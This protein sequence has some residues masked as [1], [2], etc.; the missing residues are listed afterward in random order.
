MTNDKLW[1]RNICKRNNFDISEKQIDLLDAYVVRL[2]EWNS[3]IN[4]ISRRD[5]MNVWSRH[6]LGSVA[7]LFR[8]NLKTPAD[9]V[10]VGT[11]GGL[12]GVPLA[13]VLPGCRFT[14]VDS[15]QKKL[16]AL[17]DIL[18]HLELSNAGIMCGRAEDLSTKKPLNHAFDYVIARAVAPMKDIVKWSSGFLKPAQA[19]PEEGKGGFH[20][21]PGAIL[22]LKGGDL[23]SE[24]NHVK[25][26]MNPRIL[27]SYSLP[28][29]GFDTSSDLTDKKLVV[30]YP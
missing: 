21:D 19:G 9:I 27:H 2:L 4:L 6:I 29:E 25:V 1:F 23:E 18:S 24:L 11:G 5:E 10:D 8:H 15:I 13:I 16:L 22:L 12:P 20:L 26:K 3:K 28:I 17:K 14:L 7:F 30:V